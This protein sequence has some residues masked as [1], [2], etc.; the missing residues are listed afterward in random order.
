M[1]WNKKKS[2]PNSLGVA[3]DEL[4]MLLKSTSIKTSIEGNA[5]IAQH[6]HYKVRV[7]V[8]PP[9]N[10]ES[11][12]GPIK[13]VVRLLTELPA[14]VL[15][16]FKGNHS[17]AIT[18][19]NS[20]AALGALTYDSGKIFIGSR[21]TIYEEED[22]WDTLHLPLLM[23]TIICG[24]EAI[25][26]GVRRAFSEEPPRGGESKW[27]EDDFEAIKGFL[28]KLCFCTTGGRGL[29]A[30]FGLAAG[31][32]SAI[33]GD[34]KTVLFQMSGKD[35]HPELGGGLFTVLQMPHRVDGEERLKTICMQLNKMEMAAHDLPPHF[36]AWCP[37]KL[38]N[39]IAY[40]SFFPNA[41]YSATGIGINV[42]IWAFN[43]GQWANAILA[44]LG[45]R[46]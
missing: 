28:S 30:E 19:F 2:D 39:N 36:G 14:P 25:L 3:L 29:T 33:A 17:A 6:E 12:N 43:R 32:I 35:P 26:G 1:F 11:D 9:E 22:S 42:A 20:F 41:L 18:S 40:V 31:A 46:A 45:V 8:V 21:L 13:A 34:H 10:R 38:G 15:A 44:S 7:E 24:S 4:E 5:L 23:F 37:G 16:L 27:D